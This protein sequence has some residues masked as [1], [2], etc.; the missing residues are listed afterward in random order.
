MNN[1][2]DKEIKGYKFIKLIGQGAFGN[3][4]QGKSM[5]NKE[6]V[7]I[8]VIEIERFAENDGIL[9]ELVESEQKALQKVKSK[10]V[11]GFVD[12]FQDNQYNYL[13]MEYCDSGDLEQQIKNPKT[14][15]TEQDALGILRQILQGLRDIHAACIIHR[16]LKVANILI[17]NHSIY[18]IADLGFCKILENENEQSR[19]QLGSLYTMAPEILNSNSYGLSSDMFSVGVIFYQ[20][21]YGRFPFSQKDYKLK[22]QP[23]I[24]FT[25]NKIDVSEEA[26]DLI[27]NMLQFD[28]N[29][30]ITFQKITQHKV[31]E[32]QIFSQ[33]SRIQIESARVI[34]EEHAEFYQKEG[35][36][37]EKVIQKEI[38]STQQR[39]MSYARPQ[40]QEIKQQSQNKQNFQFEEIQQKNIEDV[41]VKEK[42]RKTNEMNQIINQINKKMNDFYFFSNTILEIFKIQ[43]RAHF[44]A[45]LLCYQAKKMI[46]SI[47]EQLELQIQINKNDPDLQLDLIQLKQLSELSEQQSI[48]IDLQFDDIAKQQI[49]SGDKRIQKM[50]SNQLDQNTFN[51]SL[52]KEINELIQK[53]N[54]QITYVLFHMIQCCQYCFK[55]N[56]Y[57]IEMELDISIFDIKLSQQIHPNYKDI[58]IQFQLLAENQ[59]QY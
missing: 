47:K 10:Y 59:K 38:E 25:K 32:K 31:F 9:G 19:L 33:I 53:Q 24:N 40:Q 48:I 4:Y 8:K 12:C 15:F 57:F 55:L 29:K 43:M 22:T 44:A 27:Q 23:L 56:Q 17:H 16:D 2:I 30:R 50:I 5:K 1:L 11:V 13:V 18:K 20:I 28:P 37:I 21:L 3:V 36:K 14:Q 49:L 42:N 54:S 46:E 51:D 6:I 39:L 34:M 41:D 52:H 58:I 7:A 35:N 45:V 26:K